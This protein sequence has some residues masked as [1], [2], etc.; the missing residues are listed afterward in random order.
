MNETVDSLF[1]S[2]F[3]DFD[4]IKAEVAEFWDL[5]A[6]VP[7]AHGFPFNSARGVVRAGSGFEQPFVDPA[8]GSIVEAL[9][10]KFEDE[11]VSAV[12]VTPSPEAFRLITGGYP[13]FSLAA[14]G[15]SKT[16][17]DAVGS[18]FD[19]DEVSA[20]VHRADTLAVVGSS[21]E[22]GAWMDR[23]WELGLIASYRLVTVDFTGADIDLYP[24][25]AAFEN[26]ADPPASLPSDD[27]WRTVSREFR[28]VAP[29]HE[30]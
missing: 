11:W 27:L 16:W 3:S 2:E 26:F 23:D 21:R 17:E 24:I 15:V 28:D 18:P 10:A 12:V 13:G 5:S 30:D 1:P 7:A 9:V 22:W 25:V 14:E 8:F 19:G 4:R 6:G 20:L 29:L